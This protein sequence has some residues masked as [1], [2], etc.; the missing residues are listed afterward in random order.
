MAAVSVQAAKKYATLPPT[1]RTLASGVPT[2]PSLN[3][4]ARAHDAHHAGRSDVPSKWAG[5][6]Q[7]SSSSLVNKSFATGLCALL[8]VFFPRNL[9]VCACVRCVLKCGPPS[10]NHG[11]L[12]P[13]AHHAYLRAPPRRP[14]SPRPERI[15]G[16]LRLV[17]P[18][19]LLLRDRVHGRTLCVGRQVV[20]GGVSGHHVC[21]GGRACAREG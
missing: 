21:V 16:V 17:Q 15:P 4:S 8:C 5:G 14:R 19:A 9:C 1:V 6:Y 20:R 12:L 2:A 13:T 3:L 10:P 7:L 11:R 18:R